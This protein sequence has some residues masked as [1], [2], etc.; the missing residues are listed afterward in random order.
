M[1]VGMNGGRASVSGSG[2]GPGFIFGVILCLDAMRGGRGIDGRSHD[3]RRPAGQDFVDVHVGLGAG[4]GLPNDQRKMIVE[5]SGGHFPG[6]G[7]DRRADGLIEQAKGHIGGGGRFLLQSERVDDFDGHDFAADGEILQRALGLGPPIAIGGNLDNAKAIVFLAG[8]SGW[9]FF[10]H[11]FFSS[12][13]S[14]GGRYWVIDTTFSCPRREPSCVEGVCFAEAGC[15]VR[16]EEVFF[17]GSGR[18]EGVFFIALGRDGA[19]VVV[20]SG[21]GVDVSRGAL[22]P[23]PSPFFKRCKWGFGR[24]GAGGGA[25]DGWASSAKARLKEASGS[26]NCRKD[27]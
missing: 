12:G 17:V 10:N 15:S 5:G 27:R 26:R 2:F 21:R 16:V 3:F 6:G 14:W 4:T 22:G 1:I 8:R 24:P 23:L 18:V 11:G 13:R 25:V 7:N 9:G 19:F 20:F